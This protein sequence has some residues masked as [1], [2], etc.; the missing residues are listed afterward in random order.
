MG[1][2]LVIRGWGFHREFIQE[3]QGVRGMCEG[4][5]HTNEDGKVTPATDVNWLSPRDRPLRGGT[6]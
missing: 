6:R 2:G 4:E 3:A 1:W 5:T